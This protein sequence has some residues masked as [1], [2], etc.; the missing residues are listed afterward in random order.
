MIEQRIDRTLRMALQQIS[1]LP[2]ILRRAY[3]VTAAA[4]NLQLQEAICV[5]VAIRAPHEN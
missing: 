1:E 5:E 3:T 2:P 4:I